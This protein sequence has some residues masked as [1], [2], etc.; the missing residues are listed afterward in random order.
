[1]SNT[2]SLDLEASS[3]QYASI[4]DGSQ[5]GLDITGDMTIEFWWKPESH[6]SFTWLISKYL[7]SVNQR[8]YGVFF[9]SNELHFVM[10]SNGTA[11]S[12]LGVAWT[13]TD[14]V[15]YHIAVTYD[16]SAGAT[17]TFI[18]GGSIGTNTGYATSI[19]NGTS[20]FIV[21]GAN[22]DGYLDGLLKDVRIF[23]NI[24]TQAEI[25]VDAYTENV[26]SANLKGEWNFNN[27]YTDT[28]GNSNTLTPVNSPVFTTD[29]PYTGE[30]FNTYGGVTPANSSRLG[31]STAR[32][33]IIQ[34]FTAQKTGFVDKLKIYQRSTDGVPGDGIVA[35]LWTD[36][37]SDRPGA[38]VSGVSETI[39]SGSIVNGDNSWD[40]SEFTLVTFSTKSQ[41]NIGEK[42]WV[43]LYR[44]SSVDAS[45]YRNIWR[46]ADSGEGGTNK[47]SQGIAGTGTNAASWTIQTDADY[48]ME[49]TLVVNLFTTTDPV[50][51]ID[52]D[53]ATASGS[54]S[55]PASLTITERGFCYSTSPN[56]TTADSKVVVAG[57]S[58][59]YTGEITGL[60][61]N[62]TYYV[63]AYGVTSVGTSYG[64]DE[65]FTTADIPNNT[66][67][68]AISGVDGATY[69][70][71]LNIGG[72]TG[73]V[74]V[75]LG[76]TGTSE[77]FNAGAGVTSFQGEYGGLSGLII[78]ADVDFDG[79]IDDVY[80]VRV[81]GE[82]SINWTLNTLTNL[83]AIDSSVLLKR[84]E[85]D[86]FN[87]FR[88][89]RYL[90][91]MFKDLDANVTVTI[92]QEQNDLVNIK[93]RT[94]LVDNPSA[95]SSPFI[96]KKISFL[97]KNQAILV[98]LSN[99][100]L[101][102]TFTICKFDLKGYE[103]NK[104]LFKGSNIISVV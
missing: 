91:L 46:T 5:T 75:K 72:T 24:R 40:V 42:Y 64:L 100:N 51:N 23:N 73:T 41:V 58:G 1:M 86:E 54:I 28:S 7:Q 78:E 3:D 44:S 80:Y 74:T 29:I 92:K 98:G 25:K 10:S 71:Q 43:V 17:E 22:N 57:T 79:S 67:Y 21:G 66:I 76:S 16:A 38:V 6:S 62:T 45:N 85:D 93:T 31:D 36:N 26:T 102:E 27:V 50:T 59:P 11:V 70:V 34:Q 68:K 88:L 94:F 49:I 12:D 81:T 9:N 15:W 33:Y 103:E 8:S 14:G 89:F 95:I 65:S 39:N 96:K 13:P 77:V 69:A 2:H 47:Y 32:W 61:K 37:G 63:R 52:F 53:N 4:A 82:G 104:R 18:N 60:I 90:D 56:P 99:N 35:Q 30:I 87:A 101:N 19:H 97:S 84:L 20:D 83:F 55:N 48:A